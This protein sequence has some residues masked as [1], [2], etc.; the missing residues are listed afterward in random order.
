MSPELPCFLQHSKISYVVICQFPE[1]FLCLNE[2]I[3]DTPSLVNTANKLS[4]HL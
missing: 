2:P 3:K 1:C 4:Y